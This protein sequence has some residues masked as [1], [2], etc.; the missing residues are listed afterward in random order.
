M[1]PSATLCA[2]KTPKCKE[3]DGVNC[4]LRVN[5]CVILR[6][7]NKQKNLY[8]QGETTANSPAC[9]DKHIICDAKCF[10]S[11]FSQAGL[12]SLIF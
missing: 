12:I 1:E 11:R 9:V 5:L 6:K 7:K 8:G 3:R 2:H 10:Y 4:K